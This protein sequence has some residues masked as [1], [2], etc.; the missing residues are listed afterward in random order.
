MP[1]L[2][3]SAYG[4]QLRLG[5]GVLLAPLVINA[6]TNA[7]PILIT[8]TVPHGVVDVSYGVVTGV[9]G[10]LGANGSWVVER[11]SATQLKL[12]GSVGTGAYISGGTLTLNSTYAPIAEITN[13]EDLG[14]TATIVDVTSHDSDLWG[15]K[16]PTFLQTGQ[17]RISLNH[18]PADPGHNDT[19]GLQY[20]LANRLI[21]PFMVVLPNGSGA[22]RT[23]LYFTAFVTGWR[24]A[25]PVGGAMT[26][27]V[28][29]DGAGDMILA[30]T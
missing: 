25:L 12:R 19:T 24:E 23:T 28:T 8:T 5:D 1:T 16:I 11:V 3:I 14:A 15:S 26:A 7:T 27:Q 10:N 13:I 6:A 17:I 30:R 21:R 4:S 18:V 9:T 29:L 2:A 20:L 22:V